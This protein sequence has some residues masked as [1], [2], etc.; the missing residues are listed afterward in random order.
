MA[1]N[2]LNI[3]I[4]MLEADPEDSFVR[5]ALAKEY[6]KTDD[7]TMA[8]AHFLILRSKDPNYVGLYY[9]LGKLYETLNDT[10]NALLVY[11]DGISLAKKLN[12]HHALSELNNAKINLEL[13]L[14]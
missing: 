3:L 7:L 10:S 12:E 13:E 9:H 14:S 5:Y 6:E 11:E 8:L 1:T 4:K 2:R